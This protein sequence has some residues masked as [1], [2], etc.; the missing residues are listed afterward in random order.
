MRWVPQLLALALLV[1]SSACSSPTIRI[2][3]EIRGLPGRAEA[4]SAGVF[5]AGEDGQAF[6]LASRPLS[7][8]AVE[9]APV[10]PSGDGWSG[11]TRTHASDGMFECEIE[12]TTG[13]P[14][15]I[16]ISAS[17]PG[18]LSVERVL[19]VAS[20]EPRFEREILVL[21]AKTPEGPTK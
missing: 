4:A 20:T 2:R 17:A 12:A 9:V 8:A 10:P 14:A 11:S 16:K 13:R 18:H 15:R 7:K 19:D 1:L 5:I 3:G 21:L 6:F